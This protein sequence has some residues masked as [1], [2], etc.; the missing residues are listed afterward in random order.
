MKK[1]LF[2]LLFF[3]VSGFAN[4][5]KGYSGFIEMGYNVN[6]MKNYSSTAKDEMRFFDNYFS[7]NTIHGYSFN[8]HF[9][10]GLGIGYGQTSMIRYIWT[11]NEDLFY[12][13]KDKKSTSLVPV[14]I[15][16][17]ATLLKGKISPFLSIKAGYTM[18]IF[19]FTEPYINTVSLNDN[20]IVGN[21]CFIQPVLGIDFKINE[22]FKLY[23][24]MGLNL[25]QYKYIH[26]RGFLDT[27]YDTYPEKY[28]NATIWLKSLDIKFGVQ[29]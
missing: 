8:P 12:Y 16:F 26:D 10:L 4:A 29:F 7:I 13:R 28:D 21:R 1:T 19:T 3:V 18:D 9:F 20:G 27:N 23:Y 11:F 2:V 15:N 6:V 14:F 22:N 17:K 25:Q 5:Q 24:T